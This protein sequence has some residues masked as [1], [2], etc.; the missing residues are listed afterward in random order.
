MRREPWTNDEVLSTKFGRLTVI[1]IIPTKEG[2]Y[3]KCK[4]LVCKCDCGNIVHARFPNV[5]SGNTT[6]CGC[7][8]R[9][10][11]SKRT[12]IPVVGQRFGM[13]VVLSEGDYD[14]KS[15]TRYAIC[16]CDCGNTVKKSLRDLRRGAT[17]S[18]GCLRSKVSSE[19][20]AEDLTGQ[21]FGELTAIKRVEDFVSVTGE[22]RTQW[23]FKCS[24]G[25]EVKALPIN[26]KRGFTKSC[27]HLGKSKAEFDIAK[28]LNENNIQYQMNYKFEDLINP[29]TH[30]KL[31]FD[32]VFTNSNDE[33][34][35][36]EH[37]G[38]QHYYKDSRNSD[39]GFMQRK[40]TDKIKK[41]YCK[42]HNIKFYETFYNEDYIEH[43]KQILNE[44][45]I[46]ASTEEEI[47]NG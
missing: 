16:R 13:L 35:V 43:L 31:V 33:L 12:R 4:E 14:S 3:K 39:F 6:S 34:I 29:L 19:R 5:T 18:C 7:Y 10:R 15:S 17:R 45:G 28:Y 8:E 44:N 27:G 25:K 11:I 24:C 47:Q 26:V 9:E 46:I 38:V 1:E 32:F 36:V 21:T 40:F 23:L 42:T 37:Q 2:R 41:D 30:Y 20:S 22:R